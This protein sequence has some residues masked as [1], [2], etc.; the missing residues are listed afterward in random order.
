[1]S[2]SNSSAE[3]WLARSREK[4]SQTPL[5]PEALSI[6]RVEQIADGI[7]RISGLPEVR[8]NELLHF[9]GGQSG[10][11]LTLD[12]DAISAVLLD[13]SAAIEAGSSVSRTGEV[14]QVPVGPELLGRVIDPLGR[15]LDGGGTVMAKTRH[16]VERPAPAIIERDLVAQ[17][18]KPAFSSSMPYSRSAGASGNSSSAIARR[19][20]QRLPLTRSSTRNIRTLSR[21]MSLSGKG[22]QRSSA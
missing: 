3:E 19:A 9:E 13:E 12:A 21:S 1:M 5:S 18:S 8:L 22:R 7:A 15:P 2:T 17:Q 20:R 10:F 16:P 4:V 6:G 14:V 11:A